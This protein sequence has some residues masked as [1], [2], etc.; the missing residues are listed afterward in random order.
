MIELKKEDNFVELQISPNLE[1]LFL[2]NTLVAFKCPG[3]TASKLILEKDG[4][5]DCEVLA[6]DEFSRMVSHLSDA[7]DVSIIFAF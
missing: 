1:L 6:P 4:W 7:I 5:L 2:D 3:K